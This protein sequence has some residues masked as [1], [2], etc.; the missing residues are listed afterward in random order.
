MRDLLYIVALLACLSLSGCTHDEGSSGDPSEDH[1]AGSIFFSTTTGSLTKGLE[2]GAWQEVSVP[3]GPGTPGKASAASTTPV[4]AVSASASSV[5]TRGAAVTG[6]D[7]PAGSIGVLG[8]LIPGGKTISDV[9]PSSFMYN[10]Q[11]TRTGT[12]GNY[13]YTY[14]PVK[15][16]PDDA[17]SLVQFFAYYPYNGDGITLSPASTTGYPTVTYLPNTAVSAQVDLMLAATAS[18]V[19]NKGTGTAVSL[20]FQHVLA[21]IGFSV[22]LDASFT[23]QKVVIQSI[24]MTGL[25]GSGTFSTSS[26]SWTPG[27]GTASY[28]ASIS[29]G[30]LLPAANQTLN[31]GNY[32]TVTNYMGY[33]LLLPQSVTAANTVVVSYTVDGSATR[34]VTYTLSAKTLSMGTSY[35]YQLMIPGPPPANC[36]I[37]APSASITIPVDLKGN[38]RDVAG[39]SLPTTHVTASVGVVWQTNSG[40]SLITVGTFSAAKQTVTITAPSGTTQGNAVIAAYSGANQ[41][42]DILWSWHI[43]VTNYNPNTNAN[44]ASYYNYNPTNPLTFMDRNL[45]ATTTSTPTSSSL[46]AMG[47]LYQW[48]RKDPFPG[49]AAVSQSDGTYTSLTI[50]DKNGTALTEGS[51][52][53][54]TGIRSYVTASA[55]N[56]STTILNPMWF[57]YGTNLSNIGYDWYTSTDLRTSQNDALWG[58]A[59]YT[60]SPTTK[61]IFDPCPAGWRVPAFKS[62]SSPWNVFGGSGIGTN[63]G[64]SGGSWTTY[65]ASWTSGGFVPAAGYRSTSNGA[66]YSV[67]SSGYCWSASSYGAGGLNLGFLSSY[68]TPANVNGRTHGFSVRCVQE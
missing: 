29:D 33:F 44:G 26:L 6:T 13:T 30:S 24:Q 65:G 59:A 17:T 23:T 45:G 36:Y 40:S 54:G 32:N 52:A 55:S 28:T 11:V 2:Q 51:Q 21:R 66:L 60:G 50:Y 37:L 16:W 42:G 47:L 10:T 31:A 49:A 9:A 38:G 14:N 8:Y 18:G 57:Y 3:L 34:T 63:Y 19:N 68:V 27:S 43:W 56:L 25:T 1:P 7:A 39:T 46:A 61:T 4:S 12:E 58:S 5:L 41:T 15:Y 48:G 22:K 64:Y 35:T 67:G 53:G 20:A 62:S